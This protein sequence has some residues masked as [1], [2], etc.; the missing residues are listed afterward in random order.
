MTCDGKM[1]NEEEIFNTSYMS[2]TFIV[3]NKGLG[4]GKTI[5]QMEY[6]SR[7]DEIEK[8]YMKWAENR[9]Q[10][11]KERIFNSYKEMI[12]VTKIFN[13]ERSR[14]EAKE[15]LKCKIRIESE[16]WDNRAISEVELKEWNEEKVEF[17]QQ[18][19]GPYHLDEELIFEK[20]MSPQDL[21]YRNG[22]LN[23]IKEIEDREIKW[24]NLNTSIDEVAE[25]AANVNVKMKYFSEIQRFMLENEKF[26]RRNIPDYIESDSDPKIPVIELKME[27]NET[28]MNIIYK[29]LE[30]KGIKSKFADP[31]KNFT[32]V[33]FFNLR[34][35]PLCN[36][37]GDCFSMK[38]S[39]IN[40][41]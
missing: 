16:K 22:M 31:N 13:P 1:I 23:M 18:R 34:K 10:L 6:E 9:E 39:S 28:F 40:I 20:N 30:E 2:K 33:L 8:R 41:Y 35:E 19:F 7:K 29:W 25:D 12:T 37:I 4:C 32:L 14:K 3:Y 26:C 15:M 24:G 21:I 38:F 5:G 11:K 27:V 17:F 36:F